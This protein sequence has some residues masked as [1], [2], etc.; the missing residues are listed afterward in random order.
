MAVPSE[1]SFID[2]LK[3]EP[4]RSFYQRHSRIAIGM[5]IFVFF[6]PIVGIFVSGLPG[7]VW[8][9]VF[10]VLGYVFAPYILLK[11]GQLWTR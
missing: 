8:G 3:S 9:V 11:L 7:A 4:R 10:S 5:I 6:A 2:S 1:L